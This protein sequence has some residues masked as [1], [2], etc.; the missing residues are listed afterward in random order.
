[1]KR[2]KTIT[3]SYDRIGHQM[4]RNIIQTK[5]TSSFGLFVLLMYTSLYLSCNLKEK[6]TVKGFSFD[7][8]NILDLTHTLNSSFPYI[9][10]DVTYGFEMKPIATLEKMGVAANE[11]KI[12]EHIGTQFD[13]PSHFAKGG[14]SA[15]MIDVK[16]LFVPAIVINIGEKAAKDRDAVLTI[17]DILNWEKTNGVIPENSAV[18]IYAGWDK[19]ISSPDFLG[20]DTAHV[21]H[22]PGI[23]KEAAAFLVDKRSIA[24]VGVDVV[25][26]DP[27]TDDTYQ[28][29]RIILG[30]GKWALECLTNLDKLP[31]TGAHIFVG[32]PKVEGAT[33]GLSRV[34]AI[35]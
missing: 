31:I 20:I 1:M 9:P 10:T 8:A 26:F 13:A 18:L 27:G 34:I 16:N 22:F 28:S 11:W 33:G 17:D 32:G 5:T 23:S 12:H 19:K 3:F 35:W 2:K 6:P 14:M 24:G 29:H 21:K 15:E 25:S 4:S 30:K 7:K